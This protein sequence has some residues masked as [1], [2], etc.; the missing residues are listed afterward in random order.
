MLH[1]LEVLTGRC[2]FG[3]ERPECPVEV[4]KDQ[5]FGD[6][7]LNALVTVAIVLTAFCDVIVDDSTSDYE[8]KLHVTVVEGGFV[9][10]V[11]EIE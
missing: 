5:H 10:E 9:E 1:T 7:L 2:W 11:G 8:T 6:I 4:T 3:F